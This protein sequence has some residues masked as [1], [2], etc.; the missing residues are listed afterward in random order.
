MGVDPRAPRA[1]APSGLVRADAI[2]PAEAPK[3]K[4]GTAF[5]V[6]LGGGVPKGAA[7]LIWGKSGSGKTRVTVQLC[8]KLTPAVIVSR[9][10]PCEDM[11]KLLDVL[12][13]PRQ[14]VWITRE[15]DWRET[16]LAVR[17]RF[18][19]VDSLS[20]WEHKV[21][22]EMRQT[23]EWAHAHGITTASICHATTDGKSKGGTGPVHWSDAALVVRARGRGQVTVDTPAKNR[24]GATGPG[25]P[26]GRGSIV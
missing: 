26:V 1:A 8:R 14:H 3:V 21:E 17:P 12:G 18:V 2:D 23:F 15:P 4:T 25:R 20:V 9:E 16:A 24:F 19:L 6:V 7:L 13:I 22:D 5:D 11:A 10:M